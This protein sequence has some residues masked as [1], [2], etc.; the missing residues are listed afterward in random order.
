MTDNRITNAALAERI[1]ATKQ[2]SKERFEEILNEIKTTNASLNQ[3]NIKV[4]IQN[5]CVN[6]LKNDRDKHAKIIEEIV[7]KQALCQIGNLT[8]EY[9]A[10]KAKSS[11][12]PVTW[13]VNN[14]KQII[15]V[16]VIV[17]AIFMLFPGFLLR[18]WSAVSGTQ[19]EIGL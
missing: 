11:K 13:I 17:A 16:V 9:H 19:L 4:G 1:N 8:D 6:D 18:V 10:D 2:F 15:V 12:N 5:G 14:W 3:L 7:R